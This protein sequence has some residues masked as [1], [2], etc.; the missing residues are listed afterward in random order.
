[1][2]VRITQEC[3]A[4]CLVHGTQ[5]ELW[6]HLVKLG[7]RIKTYKIP[8]SHCLLGQPSSVQSHGKKGFFHLE[9][10]HYVHKEGC[11]AMSTEWPMER[12][13]QGLGQSWWIGRLSLGPFFDLQSKV[14][15]FLLI[16]RKK[17][18]PSKFKLHPLEKSSGKIAAP[19]RWS[20]FSL[21]CVGPTL[22]MK[23]HGRCRLSLWLLEV[24]Q[25]ETCTVDVVGSPV[26]LHLSDMID[27]IDTCEPSIH[28]SV[29]EWT[30]DLG[31]KPI[32]TWPYGVNVE[33][34]PW[35]AN[36]FYPLNQLQL[37]SSGCLQCCL[38]KASVMLS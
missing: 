25:C 15:Q 19:E 14:F 24:R 12:R 28:I 13:C 21:G 22:A 16:F 30:T 6:K 20:I 38:V 7:W 34:V 37:I 29:R 1:M 23:H 9:S 4:P 36:V 31:S 17:K 27:M 11:W 3:L 8:F 18:L 26:S 10:S 32:I 35:M 2:G 33:P 5:H